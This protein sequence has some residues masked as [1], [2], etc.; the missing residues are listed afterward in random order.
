MVIRR[1]QK[2]NK[3]P[4]VKPNN[5]HF[6]SGPCAKFPGYTLQALSHAPLGR[7][8]RSTVGKAKLAE[9]IEKTRELLHIPDDY[10]IG[11][12]PGSDT[13]AFEMAM[14]NLL[15]KR[16][17]DVIFF[18][19][20]GK[21]WA[22]DILEQLKL[23]QVRLIEADY[24][25]LPDLSQAD[26]SHDVVFTWNGTTSGV[27]I[28]GGDFI[29]AEREG[30]TLCDATSAVFAMEIPWEKLDAT[31]FSWQKVLGG[32]AAHGMLVLSPRAVEHIENYSPP[33]PLPK[34]FRLKKKGKLMEEIFQGSTINTPSML[35]NEDYLAALDW[36]KSIGGLKEL[37]R[38]SEANLKVVEAFVSGR[39]WIDFL[40][41][42]PAY[43]SNTS[44]CLTI[45]LPPEKVKQLVRLLEEEGVAYDI[46]S[47]REAPPGLRFWCGATV[48]KE[49]LKLALQW[50]EW[51]Y[52]EVKA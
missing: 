1:E 34:I 46:A 31:T 16:P 15:G 39:P 13:G 30:L 23:K 47:Y 7:S 38:R 12:V 33:W 25:Y 29:P 8:H 22:D 51:A 49:D 4:A 2:M 6:S 45:A 3:K 42:D 11:I 14:W 20:F 27:K 41:R 44:V 43:R 26:F 35:C 10:R 5:A 36:A 32:E 24:G 50:L 48:E 28:P 19:S 37:I 17:V 9:S 21:T 18:E 52:Y 40:A